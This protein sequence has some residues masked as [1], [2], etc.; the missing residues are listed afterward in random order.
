M[1]VLL[2]GVGAGDRYR[3]RPAPIAIVPMEAAWD[4]VI[5]HLCEGADAGKAAFRVCKTC[6][7]VDP[8]LH[9]VFGHEAG[10]EPSFIDSPAMAN[11]NVVWNGD[12]LSKCLAD[13]NG[14]IPGNRMPFPGLA[15]AQSRNA[16]TSSPNFRQAAR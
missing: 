5:S 8:S 16:R 4:V 14:F 2:D 7:S 15:D 13:P 11:S 1:D 3:V 9:G 6:H 10:T 12:T